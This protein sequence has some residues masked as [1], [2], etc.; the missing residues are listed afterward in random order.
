MDLEVK[1]KQEPAWQEETTTASLKNFE[2]VS[3][4]IALKEEVKSELAEPGSSQENYL[5]IVLQEYKH[6][7]G[8]VVYRNYNADMLDKSPKGILGERH[9]EKL[10]RSKGY[11]DPRTD[12]HS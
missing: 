9:T 10:R 5:E 6:K 3:E 4:V 8:I 11:L 2:Y 7:L 1:I 12:K